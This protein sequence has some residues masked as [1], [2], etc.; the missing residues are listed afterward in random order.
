METI[1]DWLELQV[2][3]YSDVLTLIN[4]G[5]SYEGVPVKGVKL[6]RKSGNTGVFL[7]GGIHAREWISPATATFFLNQL[8]TST[9]PEI[10]H[11]AENFD[12]YVFPI[13]NPDGYKF[14]FESDR[15]W[16]K[17]RKPNGLC[18][19]A[20]LNRNFD[21]NW[22]TTGSSSDPCRYDFAGASAES[23]PEAKLITNFIK[24]N[25][26]KAR[27]RTYIA[28]HSY[29]QLMMFPYGHTADKPYNY[30]DLHQIGTKAITALAKR[31]GTKF[32]TGSIHEIIYPSSGGS[33][34]WAYEE[35]KVPVAF[36]IELRGPPDSTDMFILSADQITPVGLEITDAFIALFT[37]AQR[38]GYYN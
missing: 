17:T 7:E 1:Y 38:L 11:L 10:I 9:N 25:K 15:M 33:M 21:S 37:E 16:R 34:D 23:E 20:D 27:I 24:E 13:V 12:W 32:Q 30:D 14:T 29:S 8:L 28:L 19:G 5:N 22:N 26:D 36:T 31:Y 6:S 2:S 4:L 18:R 35:A 3:K